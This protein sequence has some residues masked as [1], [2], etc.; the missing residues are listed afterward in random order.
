MG[1]E[2][3]LVQMKSRGRIKL[4]DYDISDGD[5]CASCVPR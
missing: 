3:I 5:T 2:I 4:N 1:V